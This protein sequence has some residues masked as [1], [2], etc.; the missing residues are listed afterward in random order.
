MEILIEAII[1]F[2]ISMTFEEELSRNIRRA[3]QRLGYTQFDFAQKI[4]VGTSCVSQYERGRRT[5]NL[6]KMS[7][8]AHV[9]GMSLDDLVP[10][11]SHRNAVDVKQTNIYDLIG[12]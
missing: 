11:V 3:R 10:C 5:P 4:G 2:L 1:E 8:I 9:L 7:I 6:E 12:E